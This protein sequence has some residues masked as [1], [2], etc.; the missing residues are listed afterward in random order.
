LKEQNE[1]LLNWETNVADTRIHGT[2]KRQVRSAFEAERKHLQPLPAEIFPCFEEAS[3]RVHRDGHV[4]V[5]K[6]FYSVPPEYTRRKL[7]ARWDLRMVRLFNCNG[8]QV[9]VHARI[10]D[11]HFSTDPKHIPKKKLS[12]LEHGQDYLLKQVDWIGGNARDWA[13]AMLKRRDVQGLRVLQGLISL[14]RKHDPNAI[15]R[16]CAQALK[17]EVFRL[18]Q[19]RALIKEPADQQTLDFDHCHELIRDL[20]V[21]GRIT[22][23]EVL[24]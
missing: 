2:T 4:E 22:G 11:G 12:A 18:Q 24:S 21:Y 10:E 3:R 16:A 17:L 14:P 6:A 23:K 7:W 9:A 19:L 13:E 8:D 5:A 1:Y 15:D 20:D